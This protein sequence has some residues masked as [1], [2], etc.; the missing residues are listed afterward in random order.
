MRITRSVL[1]SSGRSASRTDELLLEPVQ[2]RRRLAAAGAGHLAVDG[3]LGRTAI[4]SVFLARDT[5]TG[6]RVTVKLVDSDLAYDVGG[7]E[8]VRAIGN[9]QEL[10]DPHVLLP[11]VGDRGA[12]YY[13]SPYA[14]G[15]PL[16]GY[17]ARV[18]P[19]QLADALRITIDAARALD[20]WHGFGVA[21]ADL[22]QE[23]VVVQDGRILIRPPDGVTYGWD[24][25]RRD[26]QR[27]ARLCLDIFD[28]VVDPPDADRGWQQ[29]RE[30]LLKAADGSGPKSWSAGHLADELMLMERHALR[31][32]TG[33]PGPLHRVLAAIWCRVSRSRSRGETEAQ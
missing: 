15:E 9:A 25:G 5:R 8:F 27:L 16:P 33:R 2:L 10:G 31:R 11:V 21:H 18:Q 6:R 12:V 23:N 17:L 1:F 13:V 19:L 4:A 14:A 7:E 30:E 29:L 26:L 3:L 22:R 28:Q 24:A 20:R 32:G